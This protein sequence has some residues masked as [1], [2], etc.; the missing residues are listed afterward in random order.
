MSGSHNAALVVELSNAMR[1]ILETDTIA[2]V[3]AIAG[4]YV[5]C[6]HG[7]PMNRNCPRCVKATH[8][9]AKLCNWAMKPKAD[10]EDGGGE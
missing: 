8:D 3:H 7:T 4:Q 1:C 6:E 9:I 5:Y 10:R 2:E